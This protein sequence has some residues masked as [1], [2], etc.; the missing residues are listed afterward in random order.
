[1]WL[2]LP[3]EKE[4]FECL[5]AYSYNKL[6]EDKYSLFDDKKNSSKENEGGLYIKF[7]KKKPYLSKILKFEFEVIR[8]I[9]EK[10]SLVS[11]S[12]STSSK[13]KSALEVFFF[14]NFE[15]K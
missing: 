9:M 2:L 5:W 7:P 12:S 3:D 4:S 13:K 10:L 1:M 8:E 14:S 15:R 11:F 6:P